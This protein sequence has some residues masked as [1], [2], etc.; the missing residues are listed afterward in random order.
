MIYI[1]LAVFLGC[2]GI[3]NFY[4]GRTYLAILQLL[5]SVLTVGILALPVA[6]WT[7]VEACINTNDAWGRPL[8]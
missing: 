1:L 3:H 8:V 4:I 2:L 7:I 6:I 5:L